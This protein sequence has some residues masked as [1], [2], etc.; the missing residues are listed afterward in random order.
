MQMCRI[1][2]TQCPETEC[3]FFPAPSPFLLE[4]QPSLAPPWRIIGATHL[5]PTAGSRSKTRFVGEY[6][7]DV[8]VEW[9]ITRR[10]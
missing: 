5:H 8:D 4:F 3:F 9:H 6:A 7:S 1:P 10:R 2:K